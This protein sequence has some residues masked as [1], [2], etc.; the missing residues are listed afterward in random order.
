MFYCA[1]REA[2]STDVP[3]NYH[4]RTAL[5]AQERC[6]AT[7]KVLL[8]LRA[9]ASA[10]KFSNFDVETIQTLKTIFP[11]NNLSK[12]GKMAEPVQAQR[13]KRRTLR[14]NRWTPERR[15]R[16]AQAIREWQPWRKSTGPNT[17]DGKARSARN[18]LKHGLRRRAFIALRRED[19][20]ILGCAADNLAI[21]R[22]A[23]AAAKA[24]SKNPPLPRP[25]AVPHSIA[26]GPPSGS[27]IPS[28]SANYRGI[29]A[30]RHA[31][32]ERPRAPRRRW[33]IAS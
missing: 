28:A 13:P 17:Q 32:P 8:A 16:Q 23:V 33:R 15:A 24:G 6:R 26:I 11:I 3:S 19:R 1:A 20:R 12:Q 14:S 31:P 22:L 2:F 29:A 25:P 30:R 21:V 18:A 5:R 4:A 10:S 27:L 7:I 9:A